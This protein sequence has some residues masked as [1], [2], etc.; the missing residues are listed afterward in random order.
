MVAPRLCLGD[1]RVAL[2]RV[3][4]IAVGVGGDPHQRAEGGNPEDA[5]M[6]G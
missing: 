6:M 3:E 4:D 2:Q 5:E 1:R